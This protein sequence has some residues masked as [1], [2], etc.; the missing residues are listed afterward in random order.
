MK[1]KEHENSSQ[2]P[3]AVFVKIDIHQD[4]WHV[5]VEPEDAESFTFVVKG[6]WEELQRILERYKEYRIRAVYDVGDIGFWLYEL[7]TNYGVECDV[8]P[9]SLL[10]P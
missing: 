3:K 8:L 2:L 7:L 1:M 5:T 4:N 9:P 6:S 10:I